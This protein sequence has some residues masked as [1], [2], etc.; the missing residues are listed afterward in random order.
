MGP[1]KRN[2]PMVG[3]ELCPACG[4]IFRAGDYIA[5]VPLGPGAYALLLNY[6]IRGPNGSPGLPDTRTAA[7]P[8]TERG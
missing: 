5:L 7:I 2:N 3:F 8:M 4:R 6:T 1:L